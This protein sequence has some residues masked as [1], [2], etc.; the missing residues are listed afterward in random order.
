M[1]I[2]SIV[3]LER[4]DSNNNWTGE[5][6]PL[7]SASYVS[8]H[9][10]EVNRDLEAQDDSGSQPGLG[11]GDTFDYGRPA[12][13]LWG[14]D[15]SGQP[16][17]DD[18]VQGGL[19][20]C[21]AIASMSALA[22]SNPELIRNNIV[23]NNDGTYTVTFYE[24]ESGFLGIGGGYRP[25][26]ITVDDQFPV[27]DAGKPVYAPE[28]ADG[29][30]WVMVYEKAYAEF[31]GGSYESIEWDRAERSLE[32]MTG[33]DYEETNPDNMSD[34]ELIE[35]LENGPVTVSTV[36][37]DAD[38]KVIGTF[39]DENLVG[40]HVYVVRDV[41][42]KDGETY[43]ELYNPWGRS[44]PTLTLDQIRDVSN[45]LTIQSD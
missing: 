40:K 22:E 26:E 6:K 18:A 35:T 19:A 10:L 17:F 25:V 33:Q 44:H 23:D 43:V 14:P 28:S 24:K 13:D 16:E 45:R 12:T 9:F 37:Q 3:Q 41:Y 39:D 8:E 5:A 36:G 20:N 30:N 32:A 34:S 21:Y 15:G 42:E 7:E 38:D 11:E 29:E 31:V 1:S 2:S 27:N 4:A